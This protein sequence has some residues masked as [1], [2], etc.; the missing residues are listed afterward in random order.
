MLNGNGSQVSH[1]DGIKTVKPLLDSGKLHRHPVR[2]IVL[3][4]GHGGK[5]QGAAGGGILEKSLN[6][7]LAQRVEFLLKERGCRVLLTRKNDLFLSLPQRTSFANRN[8]ADLFVSIHTN[9]AASQKPHGIE[10]YCLAPAGTASTNASAV[11][12]KSLPG[13]RFDAKNLRLGYFIQHAM[14]ARTKANDMGVKRARFAVLR[15]L[16]CPGVLVELGFL[17][18]PPE[19]KQLRSPDYL[20]K[21]AKGIAGG[22]LNYCSAM[23]K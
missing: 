5:D 1:I 13:N 10:V 7:Q 22:I 18:N 12:W 21:L 20:D 19:A 16:N 17:S 9:S 3:D 15:D 8:N 4:P 23:K 6:L 2:T 14:I 11:S